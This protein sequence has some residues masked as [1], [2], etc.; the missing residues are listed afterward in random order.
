MSQQKLHATRRLAHDSPELLVSFLQYALDDVRALSE[1]SGRHLEQ[2][3]SSLVE[4]TSVV[5]LSANG[6]NI[7]N[8]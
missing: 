8:S 3:I 1:R 2:A 5:D 6:R 7:R 4:D